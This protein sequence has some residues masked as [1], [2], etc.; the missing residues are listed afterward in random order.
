M[1]EIAFV[2]DFASTS[3]EHKASREM[4]YYFLELKKLFTILHSE[5]IPLVI[6]YRYLVCLNAQL[7][8]QHLLIYLKLFYR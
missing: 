3:N 8:H 6:L 7:V 1:C 5:R 4:K 2:N